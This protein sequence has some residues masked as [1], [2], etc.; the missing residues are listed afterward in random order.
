MRV[1]MMAP[2]YAPDLGPSLPVFTMLC[3]DLV[4]RGHAVMALSTVPHHHPMRQVNCTCRS[5]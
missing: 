5:I 4:G 3:E 2:L 1:L